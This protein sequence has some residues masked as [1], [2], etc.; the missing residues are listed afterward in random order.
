MTT[1]RHLKTLLWIILEAWKREVGAGTILPVKEFL[2]NLWDG[3]YA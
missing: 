3:E 2:S 1:E